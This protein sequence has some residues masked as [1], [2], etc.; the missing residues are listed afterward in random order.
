MA[1]LFLVSLLFA[2]A[3]CGKADFSDHR[4][5]IAPGPDKEALDLTLITLQQ[6]AKGC[7]STNIMKAGSS[8]AANA[9]IYSCDGLSRLVMQGDGNLVIYKKAGASGAEVATWST[10]TGPIG[11]AYPQ[12]PYGYD[13]AGVVAKMQ[14]NGNFVVYDSAQQPTW[15]TQTNG[16]DGAYVA[17]ENDGHLRLYHGDSAPKWDS[18]AG[19]FTAAGC[20]KIGTVAYRESGHGHACAIAAELLASSCG[21]TSISPLAARE[22]NGGDTIDSP[23]HEQGETE[24]FAFAAEAFKRFVPGASAQ[25]IESKRLLLSDRHAVEKLF[26]KEPRQGS[27]G[28]L[29]RGRIFRAL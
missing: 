26:V 17:I 10:I 1:R 25:E 18:H 29:V 13:G 7:K 4:A 14:G 28:V 6:L 9:S 20:Y 19:K 5:A 15:N 22:N 24:D 27:A 11:P 23:C 3:A 21:V 12:R 2:V 8:L 16:Y